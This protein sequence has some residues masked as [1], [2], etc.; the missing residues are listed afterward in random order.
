MAKRRKQMPLIEMTKE[1]MRKEFVSRVLSHEKSKSAL[2]REYRISRVTGDKWIKQYLSGESMADK[3]KAPHRPNKTDRE[4]EKLIV[5][6]RQQYPAF[7][8]TKI[9]RILKEEGYENLPCSKTFNNIFHRNRMITKEASLAATPYVRFEKTNANEM[10]QGDYT[11]HFAMNDGN[12]CHPLIVVDDHSRFNLCCEACKSETFAEIKPI[13][14]R[15]FTEYGQPFSFLCD[16]GNPWG[17]AQ[18]TG[19]TKMEVWMMELGILT[20]HGK[21]HHPT[22]QGKVERFNGS[23][24]KECLKLNEFE[25]IY[26]AQKK[27]DEYRYVYNNI[28][29]HHALNLDVP[30]KIY[31][32]SNIEY[33]DKISKWE[34]LPES[35]IRKVK[36]TGFFNYANQGYFLSEAFA[37][38]EIAILQSEKENCINL[39]FR[40]F[41]IGRINIE[42][43][44]F[45]FKKA[46]LVDNDPRHSAFKKV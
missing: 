4:V 32:R 5:E 8:A 30:S 36:E 2:C 35:Q 16:N 3:S 14:I 18:S 40:Q 17:T 20:I 41:I 25:N 23:F 19:F 27:F 43:R 29:P 31:K 34:Y 9:R 33:S 39:Y 13:M 45:E 6:T 42:K 24:T 1:S 10:W 22:T 12:R 44:C 26:D 11:G 21:I 7:G 15:L 46:Y 38:K 37:G 28:R